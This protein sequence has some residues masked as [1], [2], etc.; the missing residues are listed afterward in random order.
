MFDI[1]RLHIELGNA[2]MQSGTYVADAL[3]EVADRIEHALEAPGTIRDLNGN[4]IG[5][6]GAENE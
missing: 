5:R 3:R 4:T 2:D 1:F 6:Y